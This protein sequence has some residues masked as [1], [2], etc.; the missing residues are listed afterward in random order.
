MTLAHEDSTPRLV[1]VAEDE[2]YLP[3]VGKRNNS[4]VPPSP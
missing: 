4:L 2:N 1:A 3:T